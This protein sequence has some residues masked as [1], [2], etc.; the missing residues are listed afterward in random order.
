M[1]QTLFGIGTLSYYTPVTDVFTQ[2]YVNM[3]TT[4]CSGQH[5][6]VKQALSYKEKNT[7]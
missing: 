1:Q 2:S 6:G 5:S 3:E 4:I 7:H